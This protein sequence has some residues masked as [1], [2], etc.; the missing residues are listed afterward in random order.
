MEKKIKWGVLG[1]GYIGID[2]VIPAMLR[3]SKSEL[4]GVASR[5]IEKSESI[6][7]QF[8]VSKAFGSYQELLDDTEI[9]AVYI[10][11]PNHMHVEWATKA[12]RAGKHV[13]VEK[14][15]ALTSEHALTL[16]EEAKQH[17]DL[18]IMEAFMYKHHP[19]WIKVKEMVQTGEIGVLKTI[20]SSFSFYDDD[21]SSIVNTKKY[22][23]GSLMDI[24]C[25][26]IS[27][28]RF[29]FDS[30]P[31]SVSA[32]IEYDPEMEIDVLASGV[33]EFKQGSTTFFS[34]I[35]V[36]ENQEAT[37]FGTKGIIKFGVPFN[38]SHDEPAKIQLI[39]DGV[40]KEITF[41]LCDQY[42]LEVDA[43]SI[44]ILE[45]KKVPTE[46]DD[47]VRNM[48]VIEKLVES[49]KLGKRITL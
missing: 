3:S 13:L 6:A 17:P 41:D 7:K 12:L 9:E 31:K 45:D 37:I 30:E 8:N 42:T 39:K 22:G 4:I 15:I 1:L 38:P 20:Q 35:R 19:Q 46:L 11:L 36:P 24:G 48:I 5:S 40:E 44:A 10:P 43:L 34:S 21:P 27:I 16:V 32:T 26:P 33:L 47:A 29:L 2:F 25:Y 14:P 49:D 28:S 23:G 18:K